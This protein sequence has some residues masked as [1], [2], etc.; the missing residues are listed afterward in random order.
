MQDSQKY[1]HDDVVKE[2][3]EENVNAA[4]ELLMQ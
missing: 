1:F 4:R 3:G 2:V